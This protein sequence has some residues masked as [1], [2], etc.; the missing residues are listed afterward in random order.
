MTMASPGRPCSSPRVASVACESTRWLSRRRDVDA[1]RRRGSGRQCGSHG[2]KGFDMQHLTRRVKL[3]R[4][5]SHRATQVP[6]DRNFW[7]HAHATTLRGVVR[8]ATDATAGLTDSVEAN[9]NASGARQGVKPPAQV[10][11]APRHRRP[12][13]Q[14]GPRCHAH[15]GRSDALLGARPTLT[16]APRAGERAAIVA[17]LTQRAGRPSGR[18]RQTRWPRPP[19]LRTAG[20]ASGCVAVLAHGLC[21]N[22]PA[23][24]T[25]RARP[26]R[27]IAA[28]PGLHTGLPAPQQ[29]AACVGQCSGL[30]AALSKPPP[31]GSRRCSGWCQG[32]C[33]G[34]PGDA[35]R[36]TR[37]SSRPP[38]A[39]AQLTDM[40]SGTSNYSMP[41]ERAGNCAGHRAGVHRLRRAVRAVGSSAGITDLRHGNLLDD[42]WPRPLC[43][44][45]RRPAPVEPLP[46][47]VRCSM[48]AVTLARAGVTPGTACRRFGWCPGQCARAARRPGTRIGSSRTTCQSR[49]CIHLALLAV[50]RCTHSSC[51]AAGLLSALRKPAERDHRHQGRWQGD[52]QPAILRIATPARL[53]HWLSP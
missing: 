34:R 15:C 10:K 43:S 45:R 1:L 48:V 49:L 37:R 40:N 20:P 25:G 41:P 31:A 3:A 16:A 35:Q 18:D 30:A 14:V 53:G 39:S 38:M 29:P 23:M 33:I 17:V 27:S 51:V 24:A 19:L 46:A 36:R 42:R 2:D 8:L 21:M 22:D 11:S 50:L 12:G 6:H 13:L 7:A 9:T 32:H 4:K 44:R 26:W 5:P 47:R 28:R 52:Q